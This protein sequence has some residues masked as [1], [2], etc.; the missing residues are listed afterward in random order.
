MKH[1]NILETLKIFF[2]NVGT[3][4][5]KTFTEIIL[6]LIKTNHLYGITIAININKRGE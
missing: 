1:T 2:L 4:D 3:Y 5:I 6:A